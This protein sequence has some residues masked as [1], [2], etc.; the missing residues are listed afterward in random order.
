M[1]GNPESDVYVDKLLSDIVRE[2]GTMSAPEKAEP[3]LPAPLREDDV[4]DIIDWDGAGSL[5]LGESFN[6][7]LSRLL[8]ERSLT[9]PMVYKKIGMSRQRYNEISSLASRKG[10]SKAGIMAIAFGMELT[11]AEAKALLATEG[12]AFSRSSKFDC[13]MAYFF[14]KGEYDLLRL[15]EAL[16]RYADGETLTA[17]LGSRKMVK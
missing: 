2:I 4:V 10:R 8:N 12:Y 1:K 15:N 16:Y 9:G 13:V 7:M 17:A 11:L 14:A 5:P 3:S 6:K